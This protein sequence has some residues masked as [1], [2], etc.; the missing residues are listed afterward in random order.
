[1]SADIKTPVEAVI[2]DLPSVPNP[3]V[4]PT[5]SE[6]TQAVR[7]VNNNRILNTIPVAQ[8]FRV[9]S[10]LQSVVPSFQAVGAPP[11]AYPAVRLQTPLQATRAATTNQAVISVPTNQAV[12]K[13]SSDP[14]TSVYTGYY[15]NPGAGFQFNF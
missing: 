11:P 8:T 4:V 2:S 5:E 10:P 7:V 14:S 6:A 12:K 3:R 13:G 9:V 15:S 1:M